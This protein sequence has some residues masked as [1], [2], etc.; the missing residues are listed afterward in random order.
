MAVNAILWTAKI[1]VPKEGAQTT[2][3][4]AMSKP[5]KGKA[6]HK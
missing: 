5:P 4:E 2:V 6:S 1:E 3:P